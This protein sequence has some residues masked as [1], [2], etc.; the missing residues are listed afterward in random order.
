MT[1]TFETSDAELLR[2]HQTSYQGRSARMCLA[3]NPGTLTKNSTTAEWDA[4]EISG[5]GY[6]RFEWTIP[7]AAIVP[8]LGMVQSTMQVVTFQ[9]S[10]GGIGLQFD[11]AYLVL[12]SGGTWNTS[13][14]QV[15]KF[16]PSKA[17]TAGE[18]IAFEYSMFT[19]DITVIPGG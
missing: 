13:V 6:S 7:A 16:S 12:G 11:T 10:A 14:S 3:V 15:Y 1:I 8:A 4:A 2:V 5:N 9:A 19:D 18:P 17:L